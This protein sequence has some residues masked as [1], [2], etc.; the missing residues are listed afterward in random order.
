MSLRVT[1][2]ETRIG[3]GN[4]Y[5]VDLVQ[6][7]K[8]KFV[9]KDFEEET[10]KPYLMHNYNVIRLFVLLRCILV[11]FSPQQFVILPFSCSVLFLNF[12][13]SPNEFPQYFHKRFHLK[14]DSVFLVTFDRPLFP[15]L[16]F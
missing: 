8:C 12:L 3:I 9:S 10:C 16:T 5:L 1:L 15:L 7:N 2:K 11:N 6:V 13:F 14:Y 4:T